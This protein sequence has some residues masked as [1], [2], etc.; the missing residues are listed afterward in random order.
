MGLVMKDDGWRVPDALWQR[1][2]PLLPERYQNADSSCRD[3]TVLVDQAA[4]EITPFDLWHD[5][6]RV[7]VALLLRCSKL[8][9]R[10]P[11]SDSDRP[12]A[13]VAHITCCRVRPPERADAQRLL[14]RHRRHADREPATVR[15]LVAL[16]TNASQTGA[17][18]RLGEARRR[19]RQIPGSRGSC[20]EVHT[21]GAM[22]C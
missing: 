20:R 11:C 22:S 21:K 4:E 2:E 3:R 1:I 18:R 6:H 5:L 16:L 9:I 14:W 19:A 12:S 7:D 15:G 8:Q 10:R 13:D 17:A